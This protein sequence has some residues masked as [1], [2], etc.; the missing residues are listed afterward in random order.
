MMKALK[1]FKESKGYFLDEAM[2]QHTVMDNREIR[3]VCV[4]GKAKFI[5]TI[6]SESRRARR[7][8]QTRVVETGELF[9]FAEK[10]IMVLK[11]QCPSAIVDGVVRVDVMILQSGDLVVNELESMEAECPSR[12]NSLVQELNDFRMGY[13]TSIIKRSM[14]CLQIE[15]TKKR[16]RSSVSF[17]PNKK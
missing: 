3:I 17:L 14:R 4:N 9:K 5:A 2:V 7:R 13:W 12:K 8:G 11:R 1:T 15:S 16:V 6:G 10:A